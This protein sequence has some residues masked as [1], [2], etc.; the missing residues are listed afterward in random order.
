MH[1]G[2]RSESDSVLRLLSFLRPWRRQ[3]T[4]ASLHGDRTATVSALDVAGGAPGASDSISHCS[5]AASAGDW[6]G[7]DGDDGEEEKEDADVV[8]TL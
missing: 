4:P 8:P 1:R 6:K 5:S 7:H 2:R 3:A